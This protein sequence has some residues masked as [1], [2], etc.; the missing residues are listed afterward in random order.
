MRIDKVSEF[1][2]SPLIESQFPE[3]IRDIMGPVFVEFVKL[4]Y[5]W[6]ET[7]DQP[8]YHIRRLL[9]YKD[10]D[11]TTDQFLVYFKEKY[12]KNIQLETNSNVKLL[13]K[14]SLDIYRASGTPRAIDLLFRLVFGVGAD[15]YYPAQDVFRLSDGSWVRPTYLEVTLSDDLEKFVGREI[16]G[17]HSN[18]KAFV[19]RAV[20]RR[21]QSKF[22]DI[23][24]LS[25]VVGTFQTGELINVT[26]NPFDIK[27][28]P[29]VIG[30]LTNLIVDDGSQG[31][32]IGD[33][34]S[35]KSLHGSGG[36]ARVTGIQDQ[37]GTLTFNILDGGYGYSQNAVIYVSNSIVNVSSVVVNT[38]LNNTHSYFK[39]FEYITQ[40]LG[41][42][43]WINGVGGTF[44]SNDTITSYYANGSVK[45]TGLVLNSTPTNSTAGFMTLVIQSGNLSANVIKNQGNAVV[46]NLAVTGGFTDISACGQV[47]SQSSNVML[48]VIN[49]VG[50]FL[51]GETVYQSNSLVNT[52]FGT[53]SNS[54]IMFSNGTIGLVNTAG[55]MIPSVM[56]TG[57]VSG[58][59][60]N[61]YSV[62]LGVGIINY[63]NL[64]LNDPRAPLTSSVSGTTAIPTR[65]SIGSGASVNV[66]QIDL[67]E[68]VRVNTD[69]IYPHLANSIIG[70]YHM[71]SLDSANLASTLISSLAFTNMTIGRI[72]TLSNINGGI[73]Y[74]AK[75]FVR[76]FQQYVYP[77][78]RKGYQLDVISVTGS[79]QVGEEVT[80]ISTGARGI[81]RQIANSTFYYVDRANLYKDFVR[82][83]NVASQM[84]GAGSGAVANISYVDYERQVRPLDI[85][86][87][88]DG[89]DA[90]VISNTQ[91]A[92]GSITGLQVIDSG[93]GFANGEIATFTAKD[94]IRQGLATTVLGKQ[95]VGSGYYRTLGGRLSAEKKLFDGFYYQDFSYEIRSSITLNKYKDMLNSILHVAGTLP[96]G[97]FYYNAKANAHMTAVSRAVDQD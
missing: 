69:L 62:D 96:F 31:F 76:P 75:P 16:I 87:R 37:I 36:I 60:A 88:F 68:V 59:T 2:I 65:S 54:S 71:S 52:A 58:A 74:S 64:F 38:A 70:I 67:T 46:A 10:I 20:R 26:I 56:V 47:I 18:A 17:L 21:S 81:L 13:I 34:V 25:S 48:H 63:V 42:I 78:L 82:T 4:Y 45:G 5:E 14:H 97:A 85:S 83:T 15:I 77:L 43:I 53:V 51:T 94:G 92:T 39:L 57:A 80:Q 7:Q 72:D 73:G 61:L 28:I 3:A 66:G 49:V 22:N 27:H 90:L 40:P 35:L 8:L 93:F 32:A 33:L 50:T 95:G 86:Q 41:S 11:T 89:A 12:L 91:T 9:S 6:M 79:F 55:R 44:S 30:S 24:Y 1:N 23:L 29:T 19:E 84:I